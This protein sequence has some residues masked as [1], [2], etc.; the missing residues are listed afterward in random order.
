M[1]KKRAGRPKQWAEDMVARFP[2]GT[3][4][5]IDAARRQDEGRTDFVREAVSRELQRRE[6]N[7]QG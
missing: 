3:F 2:A 1:A 5:R 6:D 7:D 4:A